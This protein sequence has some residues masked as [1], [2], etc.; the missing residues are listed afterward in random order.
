VGASSSSKV[1][2]DQQPLPSIENANAMEEEFVMG[3]SPYLETDD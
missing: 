1:N 2:E 3:L